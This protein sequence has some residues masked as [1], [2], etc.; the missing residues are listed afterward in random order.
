[1]AIASAE[2]LD[3]ATRSLRANYFRLRNPQKSG[4]VTVITAGHRHYRHLWTRDFCY[5]VGGALQLGDLPAVRDSLGLI[6]EAQR[7]DGLFPRLLD[8]IPF[9]LRIGLGSLGIPLPLTGRLRGNFCTEYGSLAF[10]SNL[11]M[12]WA[13]AQYLQASHDHDF[14]TQ[15][16]PRL[17]LGMAFYSPWTKNG[18]LYQPPFCDWQDTIDRRGHAFFTN[19]LYWKALDSL[20]T[21]ATALKKPEEALRWDTRTQTVRQ[22]ILRMFW[23]KQAGY[24]KNTA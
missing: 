6:L 2:L 11:L 20:G 7:A 24:F 5:S 22:D 16:Y 19:L 4:T 12:C 21:L 1:M 14:L 17:T 13:C 18:L 15:A 10:D 3:I 8:S 9:W 23:D